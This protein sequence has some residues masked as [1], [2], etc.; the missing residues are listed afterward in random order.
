MRSRPRAE[1]HPTVKQVQTDTSM[2]GASDYRLQS[3]SDGLHDAIREYALSIDSLSADHTR[4][5]DEFAPSLDLLQT[6]KLPH[7]AD[8]PTSTRF[9]SKP[10]FYHNQGCLPSCHEPRCVCSIKV[11][12]YAVIIF[13]QLVIKRMFP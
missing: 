12:D 9:S 4:R 3:I 1:G 6:V 8:Q 11:D 7:H 2:A 13:L 10:G 5:Q